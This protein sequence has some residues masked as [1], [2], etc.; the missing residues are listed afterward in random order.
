MN[1]FLPRKRKRVGYG[2]PS[3]QWRSHSYLQHVRTF[4]C[5]AAGRGTV[6]CEGKIQAHHVRAGTDGG[7][8]HKPSDWWC[9]PLCALHHRLV[10]GINCS[11]EKFDRDHKLDSKAIAEGI[12]KRSPHYKRWLAEQ[13]D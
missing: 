10:D 6:A 9:V 8:Q 2:K 5:I 4:E 11:Q 13:K 1:Y 7:A 12:W 3:A